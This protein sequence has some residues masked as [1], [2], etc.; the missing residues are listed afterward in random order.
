M[1]Y[2]Y[3]PYQMSLNSSRKVDQELQ[4]GHMSVFLTKCLSKLKKSRLGASRMIYEYI[5]YHIPQ[6]ML[7]KSLR[8][9]DQELQCDI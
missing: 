5:P 1:M 9:V 6:R 4:R 3:I 2:E 7:L 8:T